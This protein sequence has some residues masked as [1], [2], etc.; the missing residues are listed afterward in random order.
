MFAQ[1]LRGDP[2][3]VIF[4]LL[5]CIACQLNGGI[6]SNFVVF[7]VELTTLISVFFILHSFESFDLF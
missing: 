4:P 2:F 5:C 1:S 3:R 6:V 7:R